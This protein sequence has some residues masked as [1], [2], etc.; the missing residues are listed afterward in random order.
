MICRVNEYL[1]KHNVGVMVEEEGNKGD[2]SVRDGKERKLV[3]E[4]SAVKPF[5]RIGSH[6]SFIQHQQVHYLPAQNIHY[7]PH[8]SQ[9]IPIQRVFSPTNATQKPVSFQIPVS[10]ANFGPVYRV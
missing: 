4:E 9:V 7:K 5:S 1:S 3:R 10:P 8:S 6:K 2:G